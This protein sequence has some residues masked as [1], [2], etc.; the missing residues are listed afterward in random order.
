MGFEC[1]PEG[2]NL[3]QQDT[4][5]TVSYKAPGKSRRHWRVVPSSYFNSLLEAKN[6]GQKIIVVYDDKELNQI[7]GSTNLKIQTFC[8]NAT[9]LRTGAKVI[10]IFFQ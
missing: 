1:P 10:S 8:G 5:G 2:I 3:V 6:R 9:G 7:D 4:K